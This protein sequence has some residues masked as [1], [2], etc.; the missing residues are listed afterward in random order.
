MKRRAFL[1]L[2]GIAVLLPRSALAGFLGFNVAMPAGP[3]TTTMLPVGQ[4]AT[5]PLG[6]FAVQQQS[7]TSNSAPNVPSD[8]TTGWTAGGPGVA[9][10]TILQVWW[11][12][13]AS[14]YYRFVV[15]ASCT[16]FAGIPG[17]SLQVYIDQLP[18]PYDGATT[19]NKNWFMA[20]VSNAAPSQNYSFTTPVVAG[21]HSIQV[22]LCNG[23]HN[24]TGAVNNA[25]HADRLNIIGT[26]T[27]LPIEP[28][29]SR[30]A[31][32]FPFSAYHFVNTPFGANATFDALSTPRSQTLNGTGGN[33]ASVT[34]N[35]TSF[36]TNVW[37]GQASDPVWSLTS[38]DSV[39]NPTSPISTPIPVR[40][41]AGMYASLDNTDN[42]NCMIDGTN[43]RYAYPE[44]EL[45][46]SNFRTAPTGS[47]AF[48]FDNYNLNHAV[49]QSMTNWPGIIRVAD[50]DAGV[51]L[52][53]LA[54][55][56]GFTNGSFS[57]YGPATQTSQWSGMPFPGCQS[58]A[59][60]L[61]SNEYTNPNGVPYGSVAG[62]APSIAKPAGLN[63]ATSMAWD[64]CQHYGIFF[65]VTSGTYPSVHI[66]AE[67]AAAN[68]PMLTGINWSQILPS[69]S[70]MNNPSPPNGSSGGSIIAPGQGFG[71]GSPVVPLLAGIGQGLP[72]IG[73]SPY[74]FPSS[75][76]GIPLQLAHAFPGQAISSGSSFTPTGFGTA[77]PAGSFVIV[78]LAL[79]R[80]AAVSFNSLLDSA[81]NSYT[82]L[83]PTTN[84]A[85]WQ[86]TLYYNLAIGTGIGSG[87][88]WKATNT[89]GGTANCI[90]LGAYYR[91]KP[92]T[93]STSLRASN[94]A[95]SASSVTSLSTTLAGVQVND[96]IIGFTYTSAFAEITNP[97]GMGSLN[98]TPPINIAFQLAT[99]A[100]TFTFN[101]TWNNGSAAAIVAAAF[102]NTNI[103]S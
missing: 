72:S 85:I 58:D 14:Q 65:N 40:C 30:D 7:G 77:V 101:P 1:L 102:A 87:T 32:K 73:Q 71:G 56:M 8:G 27:A 59:N 33:G 39:Q 92:A 66:Y 53:R 99:A 96:L 6:N 10:W 91:P 51:I 67:G 54:G 79:D 94:S 23:A 100:G 98:P 4:I 48:I 52:H 44:D 76:A 45:F 34:V 68:H 19:S 70:I 47:P 21:W 5:I 95:L 24:G 36:S 49:P 88:T 9:G 80:A 25:T 46:I 55:G 69:L 50:L 64:A 90:F 20:F 89:P 61:A 42:N 15:P 63:A 84:S 35:A 93:G 22:Y 2:A 13:P 103:S 43:P 16:S 38:S 78:A 62:I 28:A 74:S 41:P 86:P 11:D 97:A 81:G 83:Q 37:I 57:G 75:P 82:P 12:C 3:P 31:T 29:G 18:C 17:N 60:W 26:G